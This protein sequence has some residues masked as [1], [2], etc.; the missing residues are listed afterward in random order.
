MRVRC[1]GRADPD[2]FPCR[3]YRSK[4]ALLKPFRARS[5]SSGWTDG[6]SVHGPTPCIEAISREQPSIAAR[7]PCSGGL[8]LIAGAAFASLNGGPAEPRGSRGGEPWHR[9]WH[10]EAPSPP[11]RRTVTNSSSAAPPGRL[12]PEASGSPDSDDDDDE[13]DDDNSGT[14]NGE[15]DDDSSESPSRPSRL[16]TTERSPR[17]PSLHGTMPAWMTAPWSMPCSTVT[18]RR[19][20]RSS[21]APR[22]RSTAPASAS[23]ARHRT[24]RTRL[25]S[26]VMAFR[27]LGSYR[28]DGPLQAWL[29]RIATR[30]AFRRQA[31]RRSTT[32]L[33]RAVHH[34]TGGE[35]RPAACHPGW[36]AEDC[37]S[38]R[39]RGPR[40]AVPRG[41]RPALLRRADAGGGR[42]GGPDAR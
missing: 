8:L 16:T 33:D 1:G 31:Q 9:P 5:T 25:R 41:R 17:W 13:D 36:R 39:G 18:G 6:I 19:F 12:S 26:F 24:R 37:S 35:R 4:T 23:W 11:R 2:V 14:G 30:H 15:V 22:A 32:G 29:V 42:P 7:G 34:L 28:G 21:I 20:V 27:S 10:L 40:R 38:Q 3:P